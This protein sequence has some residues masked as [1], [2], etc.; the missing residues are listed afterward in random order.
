MTRATISNAINEIGHRFA[1]RGCYFPC[2]EVVARNLKRIGA[3]VFSIDGK[4]YVTT[5][6]FIAQ[7]KMNKR[8][9]L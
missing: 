2:Y 1:D 7:I 3:D 9:S 5:E 6:E 4:W 8:Q